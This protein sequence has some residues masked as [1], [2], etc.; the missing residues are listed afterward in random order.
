MNWEDVTGT[1]MYSRWGRFPCRHDGWPLVSSRVQRPTFRMTGPFHKPTDDWNTNH[2]RWLNRSSGRRSCKPETE[3]L[4]APLFKKKQNKIKISS[5]Q[6]STRTN[7]SPVRYGLNLIHSFFCDP[8]EIFYEKS[9]N[10]SS[11]E[12]YRKRK[13]SLKNVKGSV[14]RAAAVEDV[15]TRTPTKGANPCWEEKKRKRFFFKET[16]TTTDLLVCS[17]LHR[18]SSSHLRKFRVGLFDGHPMTQQTKIRPDKVTYCWRFLRT[19]QMIFLQMAFQKSFR[20][21]DKQ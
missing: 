21:S 16:V 17:S 20:H 14:W 5:I 10:S 6:M 4:S 11:T 7:S 19:P 2:W 15:V 12:S 9:I 13:N 1:G 3:T 8:H 18:I